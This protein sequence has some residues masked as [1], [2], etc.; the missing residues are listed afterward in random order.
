[1]GVVTSI[2]QKGRSG[3]VTDTGEKYYN[4]TYQVVT[5]PG[6]PDPS[7][8]AAPGWLRGDEYPYDSEAVV[9]NID[10]ASNPQHEDNFFVTVNFRSRNLQPEVNPIDEDIIVE[11]DTNPREVPIDR[12]IEGN[13]IWNKAKIRFQEA[14]TKD[15]PGA[16][17][18]ITRNELTF[19][20]SLAW[21]LRNVVNRSEWYGA[22]KRTVKVMSITARQMK[23]AEIGKYFVVTYVFEFRP[24]G[25]DEELRNVGLVELVMIDE[26]TGLHYWRKIRDASG[27]LIT[28]PVDL[29]EEGKRLPDGAEPVYIEVK[30]YEAVNFN[31]FGFN[32]L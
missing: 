18:R 28:E 14:T 24:E 17:L 1:M 13:P 23:D 7:I 32:N 3:G 22:P 21:Q 6:T 19:D 11:W 9:S 26:D 5:E 15:D 4:I 20:G 10:Y 27:E 2:T 25:W 30:K 31:I 8:I 29:D 12:D 16:T